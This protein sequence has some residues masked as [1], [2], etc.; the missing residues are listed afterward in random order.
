MAKGVPTLLLILAL[1]IGSLACQK[2]DERPLITQTL[3][4]QQLTALE[5]IPA[6]FGE[7]VSVVPGL[8]R[9]DFTLWFQKADRTIVAVPVN[10]LSKALHPEALVIPRR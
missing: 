4:T 10:R 3:E 1:S 2:V 5:S 8:G 6:E 7:L 9:G